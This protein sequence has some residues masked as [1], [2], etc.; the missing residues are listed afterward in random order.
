LFQVA[1]YDEHSLVTT[2]KFGLIYQKFG[3]VSEE[4]LFANRCHSP[5]MEEFMQLL[6]QVITLSD[7]QVSISSTFYTRIFRTNVVLA[8]FS[9]YM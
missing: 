9:T 2:F 5:A 6:G 8:A 1:E 4:A 3:Q 7:H